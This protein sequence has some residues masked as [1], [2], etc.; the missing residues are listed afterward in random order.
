M[1]IFCKP[2]PV[3]NTLR[4]N[5]EMESIQVTMCPHHHLSCLQELDVFWQQIQFTQ[6]KRSLEILDH[7]INLYV[8]CPIKQQRKCLQLN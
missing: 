8:F 2:Q 6:L 7:L 1:D 4:Q 5:P 3:A